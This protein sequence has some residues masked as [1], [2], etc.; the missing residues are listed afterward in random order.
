LSNI[1][2]QIFSNTFDGFGKAV[3]VTKSPL[4]SVIAKNGMPN[5]SVTF[6]GGIKCGN[7]TA[8]NIKLNDTSTSS[9]SSNGDDATKYSLFGNNFD[10]TFNGFQGSTGIQGPI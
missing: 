4:I 9:I 3:Y 5:F 1:P 10:E 8:T 2:P 7:I 6:N